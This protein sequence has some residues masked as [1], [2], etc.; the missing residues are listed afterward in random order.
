MFDRRILMTT[1]AG[2]FGLSAFR[3]LRGTP[4]EAG[5]KAAEKFEIEKTEAEWRAQLTPQQYEILRNHGTLTVGNTVGE[6][7][8]WMHR[9]ELACRSQVAAMSCNTPLQQVPAD[10]LEATWSNYQPGTRRPYG[11]ME[12]PAL[13]RKLDRL[14]PSF[15]D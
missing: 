8:N 10:V 5:E 3:W 11:V 12:W 14:D 1:V 9:L 7:F 4:A 13:L 2:L 6:A 15:R